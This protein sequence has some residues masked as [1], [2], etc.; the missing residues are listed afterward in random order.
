[1]Q[2]MFIYININEVKKLKFE[3]RENMHLPTYN[4]LSDWHYI[5]VVGFVIFVNV[6]F[7]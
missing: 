7:S 4:N 1:M 6:L 5:L 3:R 2:Y